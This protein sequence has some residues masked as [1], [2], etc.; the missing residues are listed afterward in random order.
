MQTITVAPGTELRGVFADAEKFPHV[1]VVLQPGHHQWLT[2]SDWEYDPDQGWYSTGSTEPAQFEHLV[3]D[4]PH[5]ELVGTEACTFISHH[6]WYDPSK[7][8]ID[9]GLKNLNTIMYH[10]VNGVTYARCGDVVPADWH[11]VS[12]V[13]PGELLVIPNI[14]EPYND[15]SCWEGIDK[16]DA[17]VKDR[18]GSVFPEPFHTLED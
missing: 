6:I 12:G 14:E 7:V 15:E 10:K 17:D 5:L 4:H 9:A 2:D 18:L 8:T 13:T 1:R 16:L 11:H 3:I